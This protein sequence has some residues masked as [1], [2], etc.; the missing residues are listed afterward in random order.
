[1]STPI[2]I[3]MVLAL[4]VAVA[5]LVALALGRLT[6]PAG[7][8]A[9][10]DAPHP[11]LLPEDPTAADVGRLRLATAVPGYQRDQVDGALAA[12][13]AALARRED[14]IAQLEAALAE[15]HGAAAVTS[16]ARPCGEG[17]ADP[18]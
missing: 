4:V 14:R 8:P 6:L 11:V 7:E 3:A 15:R 9:G 16:P 13:Q 18:R 17:S 1:M 12:L 2:W 5:A 10:Q